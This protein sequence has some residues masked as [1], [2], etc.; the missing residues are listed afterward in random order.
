MYKPGKYLGKAVQ[1]DDLSR[2]EA[3]GGLAEIV[4]GSSAVISGGKSLAEKAYDFLVG[5]AWAASRREL[6]NLGANLTRKG[7]Y[8]EAL[9]HFDEAIRVEPDHPEAYF[10]KANTCSLWAESIQKQSPERANELYDESNE[11]AFSTLELLERNNAG[12]SNKQVSAWFR[13]TYS[14]LG[15]NAK[16]TGNKNE[17]IEYFEQ[18]LKYGDNKI[19][20]RELSKLKI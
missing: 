16:L 4:L 6:N 17:A 10:A 7:Q 20:R 14:V 1:G 8:Q 15:F 11:Y 13:A 3:L 12:I 9:N 19:V 5:E 2:R 18:S